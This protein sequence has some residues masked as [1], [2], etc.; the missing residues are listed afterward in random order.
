MEHNLKLKNKG[1]TLVELLVSIAILTIV[2]IA[3]ST[4]QSNIFTFAF[5]SQANLSAQLSAR[6]VI[7]QIVAQLREAA[8]SSVGGYPIALAAT[9]SLTFFSDLNN[10][11]L[12]E[13][14]RYFLSGKN[15]MQ[16]VTSPTGSPLAYVPGNEKL[17]T[18]VAN[19]VNGTSTPIFQYYDSNYAGTSTPLTD[20][21]ITVTTQV[22]IRN[23]KD[24]Y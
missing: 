2:G 10:D 9:S 13:Q 22:M 5:S 12:E 11:G 18:I 6:H 20:P 23:L 17:S 4:F 21:V 8:P 1:F 14:I 15:L 16:G 24:N 3:L 19:V 7:R